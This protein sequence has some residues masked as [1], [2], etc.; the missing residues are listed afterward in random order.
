MS[1]QKKN[2]EEKIAYIFNNPNKSVA[3]LAQYFGI[4]RQAVD[5]IIKK[6]KVLYEQRLTVKKQVDDKLAKD[7]STY[8][9]MNPGVAI[10]GI[11]ENASDKKLSRSTLFRIAEKYGIEIKSTAKVDDAVVNQMI[12]YMEKHPEKTHQEIADLFHLSASY[13][14]RLI[15][16]YEM[17][18]N[19][20][21]KRKVYI[22]STELDEWVRKH[23]EMT[24]QELANSFNTSKENVIQVI[25]K[26]DIPYIPKG[27]NDKVGID[28]E[29]LRKFIG[30]NPDLSVK[31]IGEQYGVSEA[32]IKKRIKKYNIPYQMKRNTWK[33]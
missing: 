31:K 15:K 33:L 2:T 7:I 4:S 5:L 10:S 24:Y 22:D 11:L 13:L 6:N 21:R 8:I 29:D 26:N 18:Y 16:E 1:E 28:I 12:S 20:K 30:E 17:P 9:E 3:E 32:T 27:N 19:L 23:P 25:K 14:G